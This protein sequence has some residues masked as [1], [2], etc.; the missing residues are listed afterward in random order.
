MQG[1]TA[2][3]K[4]VRVPKVGNVLHHVH[5]QFTTACQSPF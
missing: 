3:F 2:A 5:N 1:R 4:A